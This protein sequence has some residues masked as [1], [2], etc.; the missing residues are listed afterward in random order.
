MDDCTLA[1]KIIAES[2]FRPAAPNLAGQ[3]RAGFRRPNW[4]PEGKRHC[5]VFPGGPSTLAAP[6]R[7]QLEVVLAH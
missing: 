3:T 1:S 5:G 6:L 4:V 2:W 7:F